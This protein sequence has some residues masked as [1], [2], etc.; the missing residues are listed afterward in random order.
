MRPPQYL[1]GLFRS[2]KGRAPPARWGPFS[3]SQRMP[4]PLRLRRQSRQVSLP[5]RRREGGSARPDPLAFSHPRPLPQAGGEYQRS[6]PPPAC[7]R[8]QG[9][10]CALPHSPVRLLSYTAPRC[11][12]CAT[13]APP[14]A[15]SESSHRR[16]S[17]H[18]RVNKAP[19][20]C[21]SGAAQPRYPAEKAG[22]NG[23]SPSGQGVRFVRFT[24]RT[25]SAA[26]RPNVRRGPRGPAP[27][28]CSG[29]R[30]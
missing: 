18:D 12:W 9:W 4:N 8:G 21:P 2:T 19:F 28:R 17:P 29:R 22:N 27:R 30:G 13:G 25:S 14:P 6:C 24:P 20:P 16:Q 26:G 1:R 10:A 3:L 11:L 5:S 23:A 7:G 15:L